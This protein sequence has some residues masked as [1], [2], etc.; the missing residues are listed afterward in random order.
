MTNKEKYLAWA[1]ECG[2]QPRTGPWKTNLVFSDNEI[3]ALC[4]RVRNEALEEA[5]KECCVE[6]GNDGAV[7]A[8]CHDNANNI[9]ALK[10][11]E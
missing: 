6:M 1:R 9:R 5:A 11:E 2:Y 7:I 8:T 10:D 4:Q 3:V